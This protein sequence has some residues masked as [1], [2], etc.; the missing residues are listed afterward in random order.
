MAA[1]LLF[2]VQQKLTMP[3]PTDEMQEQQ[4]KMMKYMLAFSALFFY[5]VASGL[6][7]YFIVSGLWSLMERR[8]IPKPKARELPAAAETD[9]REAEPKG[10]LARKMADVKTKVEEMQKQA[11]G[12]RQ[13][14]NEPKPNT[15]N[16]TRNERRAMKKKKK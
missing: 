15:D 1:V 12:Q 16:M 4:Q 7:V 14:R 5:K 13:I 3:P 9:A 6:C 2:Y 10:W 11:E 8:L